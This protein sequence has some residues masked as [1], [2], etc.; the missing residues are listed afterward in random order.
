LAQKAAL[1]PDSVVLGETPAQVCRTVC[2]FTSQTTLVP[3]YTAW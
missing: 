2:L 3:N 1:I